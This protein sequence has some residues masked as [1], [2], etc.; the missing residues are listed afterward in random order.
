MVA[1]GELASLLGAGAM[2]VDESGLGRWTY[3]EFKGEEGISTVI[4]SGYVPC[5]NKRDN[6]GTTYQQHRRYFAKKEKK[7]EEP[8]RRFL[9]DLL[10]LLAS[11]KEE[12]KKLVICLDAN[13]NIYKNIIGRTLTDPE[14]LDLKESFLR[15]NGTKL[16]ATHFRG[17]RPIDAVWTSKELE[18]TNAA[19]MPIGYGIGDHR[20]IVVDIN[21]E[22]TVGTHPQAI[23]RP[24][25]RRL[26]SKIPS[27][28]KNYN[29]K[30]EELLD[31][32][33]L[34]EKMLETCLT[35]SDGNIHER[36]NRIDELARD[37]MIHAEKKCRK[38]KSGNI[39]FSPEASLWIKRTQFYRT[40]L[41]YHA[42]KGKNRGKRCQVR[43]PFKLSVEEVHAR[44]TECKT[45]CGYFKVHGSKYRKRHL[46]RRL[47]A[48]RDKEDSE[49]EQ[50]ILQIIQREKD[51]AFW[52]RL[53]WSLGKKRGTSVGA[54][55]VVDGEGDTTEYRTQKEVQNV[56]WREVHQKRYH[57]AEEAPICQG[58]LRGQFGYNATSLAAKQV[59]A[60]TYEFEDD[61][62]N[63]TARIMKA[64]ADIR[65]KIP[66]NSVDKIITREVWQKKWKKKKEET[67]SSVSTLHFGHYISGAHSDQISDFHALKTSLALVHGIAL[68][69]WSKGLCV[70]L[71]KVMGVRLINKLRAIL[72]M[73]A[74]FNAANKILYGERMMDNVRKYKLMP[75]EIFSER[76]R[77]ATDGG[78]S[79]KL[80]YD[81]VRQLR[82]PAG[83]ASV[84]AANCY[85]RV[86]HAIS[87]MVFQAFGTP[88]EA[89]T[90][91]HSAIQEMQFFLRTAFGDSKESV[92]ARVDLKTQGFMQG[93]GAAPAG[94]AVVSITIIQAHKAE[95]H[96]ATFLCPVSKLNHK[97]AGILYVDDTDITHLDLSQVQTVSEAHASLQASLD[98]WSPLLI[99]TDGSL[100]PE[101]CFYHLISFSWDRKGNWKYE[102]N[103]KNS[104]LGISIPLP[105]G[106]V[107]A[108]DH[109]SVDTLGMSSC[110]SGH[111]DK[112]LAVHKKEASKS[113]LGLMKEKA[114]A[115]AS[116]AKTSKLG[117]RDIHFSVDRKMW[118]KKN[119]ARA[120][121]KPRT[122]TW[123]RLCTPRI[124]SCAPWQE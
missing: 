56:I 85:D 81:I 76:M 70:M 110:P 78:M 15:A 45:Q 82:R 14:G 7:D 50:R 83:I 102:A 54:V 33:K 11:W 43:Q 36:M 8:R 67:S 77:E 51:R 71:E 89:C 17:S 46:D 57:M 52:R 53:N 109:L 29:K 28:L 21:K 124:S 23:V 86:A 62:H 63:G 32:H 75:E 94:W 64:I 1:F 22:S 44:L 25:A 115:W 107:A 65:G 101:K 24:G 99:A 55:Q 26:N 105:N 120:R 40:L 121:T 111:A 87:S 97:L 48:A 79:K 41:R 60:G 3:M 13:E 103:E 37:C 116:Q 49:A 106:N 31:Q 58:A 68:N 80:F 19:A 72:L 59:L 73:E 117:P 42:G 74:D 2:G 18:I 98:S 119:T 95:G 61:F 122:T 10:K 96:G 69:R 30:L 27:C 47:A 113:A 34:T 108:I 16:G 9:S 38:L 114:I 118:P 6:S 123:S 39:P 91:M 84:D 4:V 104:E 90:S 112:E 100:K 92:G 12:G 5:K 66:I 88:A 20:M 93:N 35:K